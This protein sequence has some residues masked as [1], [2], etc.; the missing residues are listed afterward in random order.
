[1]SEPITLYRGSETMTLYAPSEAQRLVT[2]EGWQ[3]TP[4]VTEGTPILVEPEPDD[5]VPFVMRRA[6]RPRKAQ[7]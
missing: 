5:D 6:G 4:V 7:L 3:L 1:M 2:V